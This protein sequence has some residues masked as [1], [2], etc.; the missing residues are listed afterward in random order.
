M[1]ILRN[2]AN[3]AT[4]VGGRVVFQDPS[5]HVIVATRDGGE[6]WV[7]VNVGTAPT[8]HQYIL[9]IVER[10][11]LV[12]VIEAD[13]MLAAING[14]G[15]IALDIRFAT[16]SATIEPDSTPQIAQVVA[17]LTASPALRVGVEGHTDDVG[18]A[19]PNQAL[20]DSRA[21]AVTA[22]LVA[23]GIAADRLTPAGFGESRPIADNRLPD[24][25]AKNRRVELVR[26]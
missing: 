18:E 11:P 23:E 26:K 6:A 15:F 16:G 2:Y 19:G 25:R 5:R 8:N 20:S 24:G 3:A 21:R 1:N 17:L 7:E 13:A 14:V 10:T 9:N 4:A 12:Q 22:R